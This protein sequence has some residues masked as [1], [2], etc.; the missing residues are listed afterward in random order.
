MITRPVVNW[1]YTSSKVR[2][3][4]QV[5][6]S[7]KS[8]LRKAMALMIEAAQETKRVIE[9]PPL[10]CLVLGFGDNGV[11][12]ELRMWIQDPQN[13]VRNV[14][15]DVYLKIWDKFHENGIQFPFPQRDIHLVDGSLSL[16]RPAKKS[17]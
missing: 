11:D 17:D 2:Q 10:N 9:D 14:K 8:D 3:R 16:A 12:L 4:L 1:T 15:S 6:I 7:Y 5:S 13:G